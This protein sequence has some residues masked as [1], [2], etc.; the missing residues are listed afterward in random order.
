MGF[1][2]SFDL[3]LKVVWDHCPQSKILKDSLTTEKDFLIIFYRHD[4]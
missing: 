1:N 4:R 2:Q 3:V